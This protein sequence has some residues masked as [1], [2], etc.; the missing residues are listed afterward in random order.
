MRG[1]L[2]IEDMRDCRFR[3]WRPSTSDT[4]V[5]DAGATQPFKIPHAG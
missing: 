3:G 4:M 2:A 5:I 1:T